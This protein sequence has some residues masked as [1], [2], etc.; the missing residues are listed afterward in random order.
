MRMYFRYV[1]TELKRALEG[2]GFWLGIAA[3]ECAS[4]GAARDDK[5]RRF[6][7]GNNRRTHAHEARRDL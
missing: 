3:V 7:H 4:G 1:R 6:E 2:V 5:G